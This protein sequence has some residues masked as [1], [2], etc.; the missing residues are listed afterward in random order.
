MNRCVT[1]AGLVVSVISAA[2]T[3]AGDNPN[4]PGPVQ[5]VPAAA[6]AAAPAAPV[7]V[8]APAP[9][10]SSAVPI[11]PPPAPAVTPPAPA[12]P[13]T[14]LTAEPRA[15]G[16]GA[17]TVGPAMTASAAGAASSRGTGVRTRGA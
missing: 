13:S 7:Q 11:A 2:C 5:Y 4:A 9:V 1:T 8:P 17:A 12:T 3:A 6:I 15:G 10:T 16:S 14:D